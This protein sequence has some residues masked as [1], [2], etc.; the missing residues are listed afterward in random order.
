MGAVAGC[1]HLGEEVAV[2]TFYTHCQHP[3]LDYGICN[4]PEP[5]VGEALPFPQTSGFRVLDMA[6]LTSTA[7]SHRT[8]SAPHG[9]W[10]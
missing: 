4:F 10:H 7:H 3:H 2:H 9:A 6:V 1:K 5:E 8:S